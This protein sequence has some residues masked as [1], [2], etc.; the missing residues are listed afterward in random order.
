M[1]ELTLKDSQIS[2]RKLSDVAYSLSSLSRVFSRVGNKEIADELMEY[3]IEVAECC[4]VLNQV[5]GKMV[6]DAVNTAEQNTVNVLSAVL[7]GVTIG[8]KPKD[9]KTK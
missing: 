7:A 9:E 8:S 2:R 6:N 5:E 3:S 4:E 1:D